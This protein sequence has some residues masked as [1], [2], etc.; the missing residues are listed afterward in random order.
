MPTSHS[1]SPSG[2]PTFAVSNRASPSA[3]C[4]TRAAT[5]RSRRARS[6]G[7]IARQAGYAARAA[8]TARSVSS[9]PARSSCAMGRSVA[10]LRTSSAKVASPALEQPLALVTGDHLVELR[11]LGPS[12]VEVVVDHVV[13][14][15]LLRHRAS[16]QL[17]DR[18]SQRVRESLHLRLVGVAGEG[19]RKLE[20][21]LD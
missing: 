11:L 4:S 7:F 3:F 6:A 18:I 14:E 17:A 1:E 19:R 2:L 16:L 10:G 13:A 5:R 15:G 20:L 12:V 9:I 21:L 8:A